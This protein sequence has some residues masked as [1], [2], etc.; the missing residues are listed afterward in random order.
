MAVKQ[1]L[2]GAGEP[3]KL[4]AMR[5]TALVLLGLC[6]LP[7]LAA[8]PLGPAEVAVVYNSAVPDSAKLARLYC[9]LRKV[10]ETNLIGLE[11]PVTA[12]ISRGEFDKTIRKPL[13]VE[14]DKRGFWQRGMDANGVLMPGANKIRVLL[15]I[16][17]VPLRIQPEPKPADF[18]EDPKDPIA[19]RDEAAVD[20]EL[21]LLGVEGLPVM[22]VLQNK[23]FKSE[24]PISEANLPYIMLTARIDAASTATCERMIRDA[25]A[26]ES[27]GLWGMAYVDIANKGR[28]GPG[29]Q[30][31]DDWLESIAAANL[32]AGIPTVVDR[33]NDTFPKN[34]PMGAAALYYGWYDWHASGPFLN[35]AFKF[36]KG[37]VAMHLHSF[38]AQQLANATQNW[39]APLLEKGAAATIGNVY[40]PYLHL[41]HCFDI[42]HARLLAGMSWVEAAWAAIPVASWQGVVL[43]DPLYRPFARFDGN[44][45]RVRENTEFMA[46]RVGSLKW[47][48][49]P[50][51]LRKQLLAAAE[52]M[53]SGTL[54]EAI[55]LRLVA[56]GKGTEAKVYFDAAKEHY[57]AAADQLR[58][59]LHNIAILRAAPDGKARAI[60]A[61]RQARVRYGR[62]PE[63]AALAAW[64]DILDPPPPPP[65]VPANKKSNGP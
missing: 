4:P 33:F 34:Y 29:Y 14:F 18:K 9:E 16:R 65:A 3:A 61:L 44:G 63:A 58:Q 31:G 54:S 24:I 42:L 7:P 8:A 12:D 57:P 23:Y 22:G 21:S 51:E 62:I 53:K 37:A 10:P 36:R 27:A 15:T 2:H 64:L 13:K 46:L 32:K 5:R 50:A 19:G 6:C 20:S 40:E 35:P 17:G 47:G 45:P 60:N 26:T 39:C 11:M 28:E 49:S 43:G 56:D 52:R 25:V 48:D 55:G 38:S 41:T 1:G 30:I 59:D